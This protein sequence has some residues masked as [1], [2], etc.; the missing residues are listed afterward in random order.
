MSNKQTPIIKT[1]GE[2]SLWGIGA[3]AVYSFCTAAPATAA[4]FSS[5]AVGTTTN[6]SFSGVIDTYTVDT[7]GIYAFDAFGAQ[8]GSNGARRIGAN[9]GE[10]KANF[11]LTAGTILSI[12]IGQQGG[13]GTDGGTGGGGGTFVKNS[14]NTILLSAGGGGGGS[15]GG[16]GGGVIGGTGASISGFQGGGNGNIGG[17]GGD[18]GNGLSTPGGAIGSGGNGGFGGGG[19]GAGLLG[20]GGSGGGGFGS[21]SGV[22]GGNG[23]RS[24]AGGGL[25]GFD[26]SLNLVILSSIVANDAVNTGNGRLSITFLSA[27]ATTAVPEPFTIVGT[28]IGGAAALHMREK[29]KAGKQQQ[30]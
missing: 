7:T 22:N 8:G 18:G 20:G 28:I 26:T 1:I 21:F 14:S 17:R 24:D 19:G 10:L 11:N 9:G 23:G 25:G 15:G 2:L 6:I 12:L 29:L 13:S 16:G 3:M 5:G 4:S 30:D 27:A